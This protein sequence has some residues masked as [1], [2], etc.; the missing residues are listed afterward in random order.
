MIPQHEVSIE[1]ADFLENYFKVFYIE[2]LGVVEE[3]PVSK[4]NLE[5]VS[6]F[7]EIVKH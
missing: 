3:L 1:K 5:F 2:I 6:F 4:E 7:N